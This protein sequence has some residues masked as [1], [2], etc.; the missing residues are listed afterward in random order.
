MLFER[1]GEVTQNRHKLSSTKRWMNSRTLRM[2]KKKK[3]LKSQDGKRHNTRPGSLN[4]L[5]SHRVMC[6][7]HPKTVKSDKIR[8]YH[9]DV[10]QLCMHR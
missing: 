5:I 7:E 3:R 9:K 6:S 4:T 2:T 10:T 1:I 8:L